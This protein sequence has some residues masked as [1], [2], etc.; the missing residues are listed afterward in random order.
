MSAKELETIG[1]VGMG[2]M[3]R[4]IAAC[5]LGCGYRVIAFSRPN[6]SLIEARHQIA[7]DIEDLIK[8]SAAPDS[9]RA[10]WPARYVEAESVAGLAN[11][12]FAIESVI[13]HLATKRSVFDEIESA[14][15]SDVPIGSN[16]SALPIT[17]LQEGR[18][19]PQRLVGMHFCPPVH[20]NRLEII[21]GQ[22][23]DDATV[24][25]AIRLGTA[26]GKQ[27]GIVQKD[28]EGF[29]VNRMAYAIFREALHLLESGVADAETIDLCFQNVIGMWS[30]IMGPLR[31]MDLTGLPAYQ[32]VMKRLL[33]TLNNSIDVP[34]IIDKLVRE[35][36]TFHGY[37]PGESAHWQN[38]LREHAWNLQALNDRYLAEKTR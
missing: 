24:D 25:S 8:H 22:K 21:R 7:A 3:G 20:V 11:C 13:E 23:T 31:W 27:P 36:G 14:I 18:R 28:V 1:I 32:A 2:L 6:S 9:L 17:L 26:M 35:S 12:D 16:T 5:L 34:K 33:P 29:V 10:D 4:G 38:L 37:S 19:F 30:G 15:G